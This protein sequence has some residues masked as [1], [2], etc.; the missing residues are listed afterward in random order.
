MTKSKG[1][2]MDL[3]PNVSI[4]NSSKP[5]KTM[6]LIALA[7]AFALPFILVKSFPHKHQ[8]M[9]ASSSLS[10]NQNFHSSI[11]P[12]NKKEFLKPVSRDIASRDISDNSLTK[13]ALPHISQNKNNIVNSNKQVKTET[14]PTPSPSQQK[15]QELTNRKTQ[16]ITW[17]TIQTRSGDSL[18]SVFKRLG[19]S[20][21]T[22]QSIMKD[23]PHTKVLSH[24]KTNEQL[25]FLI[26]KHLLEKMILPLSST[27]YLEVYRE[28]Q[29]FKVKINTR[30]MN[31][32]NNLIT[33]TVQGSMYNTAKRHN[34]PYKLIQQMSQ[35]FTWDINF[36]RDVRGGDQ[37][38]IIYK[39]FYIGDKLVGTGDIQAVSYKTRNKT[40]QAILHTSKNGQSDYYTPEGRSLRKAFDRY[41][42]QFS[43]ISSTFSLSRY[44]PLLHY[45]RPHKGID[46]AARIGTPIHATGDGRIE[47]IGRQS[48]Y[49]N[50]IKINHNNL[51]STIY[52]HML[53]FQKGLSRGEFVKR[54][55][56]IGYVGQTGLASGPHCHYEF[57]INHQPKNPTTID[58]PR[59]FPIS[60]REMA[61][62][63][64]NTAKL[65]NQLNTFG[66]Q[67]LAKR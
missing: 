23:N 36:A 66:S 48:G 40:Y 7:I 12:I 25:K 55:Q 29:H 42:L 15:L 41:P 58:L 39:A 26:N 35:I 56:V 13:N 17:K 61:F 52:G 21:Q 57:H 37:F 49:G 4:D 50:M 14:V 27:Q 1:E 20:P 67:Q 10:Q 24:L 64:I 22:L 11:P 34:I 53:R 54:G 62:F 31:T 59:G 3:R 16:E 30:K 44:H 2:T 18:A 60:P 65:L 8:M 38:T 63:K 9:P 28:G 45:R 19:I 47:I 33:A 46:L 5:S 32:Q 6:A 51:Y 43:H